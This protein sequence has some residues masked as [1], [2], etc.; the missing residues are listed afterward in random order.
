MCEHSLNYISKVYEKHTKLEAVDINGSPIDLGVNETSEDLGSN[1]NGIL[2][3]RK[4]YITINPKKITY[5]PLPQLKNKS[6]R[7]AISLLENNAFRVGN[8]Y[9]D[10]FI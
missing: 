7:Q 2:E 9:L 3:A 6:L 8:L 5:I 4:I 1:G 10:L